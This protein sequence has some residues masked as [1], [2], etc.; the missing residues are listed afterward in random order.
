MSRDRKFVREL[1]RL[2][3]QNTTLR[4]V[5]IPDPLDVAD[6]RSAAIIS[7]THLE[8]NLRRLI[9]DKFVKLSDSEDNEL[10]A[11]DRL[12]GSFS[13]KIKFA[14]A[15]G[16]IGPETK[17]DL[18]VIRHVRNVFAHARRPV[19]FDFIEIRNAVDHL[20]LPERFKET[21]HYLRIEQPFD[22]P[23]LRFVGTVRL[24]QI[25]IDQRSHPWMSELTDDGA[26]E[27]PLD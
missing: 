10:F 21:I 14:H 1:K 19:K 11:G 4:D 9:R 27:I 24:Y 7:S 23:R 2:T 6:D 25:G 18:D 15:L 17:K 16:V 26:P 20:T 12:L 22:T 8:D 3:R 5:F 13:A